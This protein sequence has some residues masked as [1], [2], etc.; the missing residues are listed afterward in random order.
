MMN[1]T[2]I[3]TGL[4]YD[5]HRWAE[6]GTG[7]LM[8]GCAEIEYS[9]RLAGHSDGDAAAHCIADA[10]LSA[11]GLG[12]LGTNFPAGRTETADIRGETILRKTAVLAGKAGFRI[13]NVDCTVICD[14]PRLGEH[15]QV[16]AGATARALG[17]TT[18]RVS[19]KPRHAEGLGFAGKNEGVE[20]IASV[21]M[22]RP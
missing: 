1:I 16:M 19:I 8:L 14:Y 18:D 13:G 20:A 6:D 21:L 12:D 7:P 2:D 4:G 10:I 3:R 11:C 15:V 9:R 17:I 5:R 22:F